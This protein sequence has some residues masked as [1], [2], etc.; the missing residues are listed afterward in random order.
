MARGGQIHR[1]LNLL[2][3]LQ[4]RGV[5]IPLAQLAQDFEVSDRTIQIDLESLQELGFPVEYEEDE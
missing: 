3:T 2:R 1:H 4:T 5:G